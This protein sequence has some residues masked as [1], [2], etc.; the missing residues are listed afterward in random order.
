MS[1]VVSMILNGVETKIEVKEESESWVNN[2]DGNDG[3]DDGEKND[4]TSQLNNLIESARHIVDQLKSLTPDETEV[5][6]GVKVS[7]EGR[8]LC[9]AEVGTEAQ[10]NVT[11]TWKQPEEGT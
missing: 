10:F 2:S 7:G 5:S 4:L 1:K 3:G 11:M 9:F 8:L 6:F